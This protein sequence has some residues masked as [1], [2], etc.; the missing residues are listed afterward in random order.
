MKLSSLPESIKTLNGLFANLL[1]FTLFKC[2][3]TTDATVVLV[4]IGFG[5]LF[6]GK[7]STFIL[8]FLLTWPF[9]GSLVLHFSG[10]DPFQ[11]LA[12]ESE[13]LEM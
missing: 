2:V 13:S 8:R 5:C 10:V 9:L 3:A 12:E 6:P 11:L 4:K 1:V 7:Q